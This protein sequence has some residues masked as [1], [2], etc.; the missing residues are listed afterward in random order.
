M[1]QK[2]A[3]MAQAKAEEAERTQAAVEAKIREAIEAFQ[4]AEAAKAAAK[5]KE[6]ERLEEE[7]RLAEIAEE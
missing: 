5:Q 7:Q 6:K 4:K 2:Q 1:K 3:A